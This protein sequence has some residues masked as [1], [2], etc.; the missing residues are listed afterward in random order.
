MFGMTGEYHPPF[1]EPKMTFAELQAKEL[2][3][4]RAKHKGSFHSA[5]EAYGVIL[6]EVDEFWD[7]VKSDNKNML[8][9]LLQIAA[10]AQ[11][12]AED[13]GLMDK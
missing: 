5:H 2:A 12:A 1:E 13:L 7:L 8:N 3:K 11:R 10:M 9:E 4:A 6:E